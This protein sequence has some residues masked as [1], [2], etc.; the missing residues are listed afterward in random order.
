MSAPLGRIVD[1]HLKLLRYRTHPVVL[2]GDMIPEPLLHLL[3]DDK[4]R[5]SSDSRTRRSQRKRAGPRKTGN[6]STESQRRSSGN[7][8]VAPPQKGTL[9][10]SCG[11]DNIVRTTRGKL[12]CNV[13]RDEWR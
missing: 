8:Q 4:G 5:S 1:R 3:E 6:Q 9:C 13:C 10:P 2:A 11:S 7:L 12:R